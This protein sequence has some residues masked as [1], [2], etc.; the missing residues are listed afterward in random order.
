MKV[1][2]KPYNYID[3]SPNIEIFS[4]LDDENTISLHPLEDESFIKS[5]NDTDRITLNPLALSHEN[6]FMNTDNIGLSHANRRMLGS[7]MDSKS[8]RS[9]KARLVR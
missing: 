1:I 6:I 5:K 3:S 8:L 9:G 2:Q 7:R 4:A